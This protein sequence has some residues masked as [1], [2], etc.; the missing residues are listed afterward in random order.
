M[1]YHFPFKTRERKRKE[2]IKLFENH[3]QAMEETQKRLG[4]K[5]VKNIPLFNQILVFNKKEGH[6]VYKLAFDTW[7]NV[8]VQNGWTEIES[9][10]RY[11]TRKTNI[12]NTSD[13]EELIQGKKKEIKGEQEH[14]EGSENWTEFEKT[15]KGKTYRNTY[16]T[17]KRMV[18][19]FYWAYWNNQHFIL[20][21][22]HISEPT[23]PY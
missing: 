3:A 11:V 13:V 8:Y 5:A 6:K 16:P 20:S 14:V 22:I 7:R 9:N 1:A 10:T 2:T 21:L 18:K 19:E 12:K 17:D 15:I 4:L 23:R